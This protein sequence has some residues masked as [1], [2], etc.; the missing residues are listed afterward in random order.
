M[1]HAP[2]FCPKLRILSILIND[3]SFQRLASLHNML[4]GG[5]QT[6]GNPLKRFLNP[7]LPTLQITFNYGRLLVGPLTPI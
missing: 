2:C 5:N 1:L 7:S 6:D 3:F 4:S